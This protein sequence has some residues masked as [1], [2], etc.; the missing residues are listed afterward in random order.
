MPHLRFLGAATIQGTSG[1]VVGLSSRRHPLALLAL[2]ASTPSR[3]LSRGKLVGLLWPESAEQTARNRLNTCVHQIRSALGEGV[4]RSSGDGLWLCS[5]VDCDVCSFEA[6]IAAGEH[7]QAVGHYGGAF[8]DGFHMAGSAEFEDHIDGERER[9]AQSYREAL[10]SLAEDAGNTGRPEVAAQWWRR[11]A[12]EDRY[13][14]RVA[15]RLMEALEASGNRAEAL[16][17]ARAH[18]LLLEEEFGTQPDPQVQALADRLM[19]GPAVDPPEAVVTAARKPGPSTREEAPVS[20]IA[21]LPFDN[22]SG[23]PDADPFAA[24]LHDDLLTEL[25]RIRGLKVI[26]RTSVLRYRDSRTPV[27]EIGRALGVGTLVEGAV[28]S[29]GGRLRVNVQLIDV[30]TGSHLW[31]ERY[32]RALSTDSLFDI[33]SD[34]VERIAG[35]LQDELVPA[36]RDKPDR[37]A[38]RPTADLEAYR[39]HAQG[40]QRLVQLTDAS[41]LQAVSY[42][43]RAIARDPGYALAWVGLGDALTARLDYAYDD[44]AGVMAEAV[45]AVR[46]ALALKPELP[47]AHAAIGKLHS[48]QRKGPAAIRELA[49]AVEL[50]PGYGQAHDW[51]SWTWQCLGQRGQA[52]DSARRAVEL[53]PLLREAVSNF[54]ISLLAN[55]HVEQALLEA[56]RIR[57]IAPGWTS[58]AFYE[59]LVLYRLQRFEEAQSVL[60]G[61]TVEWAGSGPRATL[62]LACVGSGDIARAR[63]I[64]AELDKSGE[65]FSVGLVHAALGETGAAF[66]AFEQVVDWGE[67]WPTLAVNEYFPDLMDTLGGDAR[68]GGVL[69]NIH[70]AWGLSMDGSFPA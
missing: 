37:G 58:G 56:R 50:M 45:E 62:A 54:A 65:P 70:R 33:Q 40:Q 6:A 30:R 3:S 21:V 47:E 27:Q 23:T 4:L 9:L 25:S 17:V 28:Q 36:G 8:L 16:R 60:Q 67:Y 46:H 59:G 52:L 48:I 1:T 35:R 5:T 49:R 19:R 38:S 24:G 51:L 11:R 18:A 44:S 53:E 20:A 26:A 10:E 14:S 61:L 66:E 22:L 55:G 29:S 32:D 2:L 43:R 41:L 7:A 31:A 15:R 69:G 68:F 12:Q 13:D 39:L 63:R 42:F 34:L 57:E 64:L